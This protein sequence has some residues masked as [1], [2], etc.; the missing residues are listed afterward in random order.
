MQ[1]QLVVS[2]MARVIAVGSVVVALSGQQPIRRLGW[3]DIT[4]KAVVLARASMQRPPGAPPLL[5]PPLFVL[6]VGQHIAVAMLSAVLALVHV[7]QGKVFGP[8]LRL[9]CLT[10]RRAVLLLPCVCFTTAKAA[11]VR[12]SP[13]CIA[14]T[15]HRS[16]LERVQMCVP[17]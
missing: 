1:T 9:A 15:N 14:T 5:R 12:R 2:A 11:T 17:L 6:F 7:Q 4:F 13:V 16:G 10:L 3:C 8:L